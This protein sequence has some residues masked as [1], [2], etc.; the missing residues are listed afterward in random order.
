M[1]AAT[2]QAWL[3]AIELRR[4]VVRGRCPSRSGTF[5]AGQAL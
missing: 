3:I 1:V 4:E 2:H 5:S